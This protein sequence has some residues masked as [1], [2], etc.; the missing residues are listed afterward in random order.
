M[1]SRSL[2]LGISVFCAMSGKKKNVVLHS[3]VLYIRLTVFFLRFQ[4][5]YLKRNLGRWVKQYEASKTK[6]I[7]AMNK[8]IDWL[9]KNLP[10][11][12]RCTL[13]HGDYR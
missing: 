3:S 2:R 6:E 9:P 8:L 5:D 11:E 10:Q 13:V 12:E 7:D 1:S 4:G